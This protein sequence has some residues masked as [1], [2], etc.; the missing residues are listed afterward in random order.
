MNRAV[1]CA[2]ACVVACV[3]ASLVASL[4]A[5]PSGCDGTDQPK[6]KLDAVSR[7]DELLSPLVVIEKHQDLLASGNSRYR[8]PISSPEGL[9]FDLLCIELLANFTQ[10]IAMSFNRSKGRTD[11]SVNRHSRTAHCVQMN[12]ICLPLVMTCSRLAYYKD[13]PG[14][15]VDEYTRSAHESAGLHHPAGL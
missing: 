11:R 1:A 10:L 7:G 9:L 4:V 12:P 14:T 6:P 5:Q 13:F 8:A 3:V 2:V 15:P